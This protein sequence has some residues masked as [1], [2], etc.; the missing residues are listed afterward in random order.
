MWEVNV[1]T[2]ERLCILGE[3]QTSVSLHEFDNQPD[4][5][6]VSNSTWSHNGPAAGSYSRLGILVVAMAASELKRTR[7]RVL[8]RRAK[9]KLTIREKGFD[10]IRLTLFVAVA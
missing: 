6:D 9:S 10:T 4:V 2:V 7:S 3:Q 1:R 8:A 5:L